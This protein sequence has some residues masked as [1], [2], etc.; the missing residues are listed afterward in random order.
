[1]GSPELI[2]QGEQILEDMGF[3]VSVL[4]PVAQE[5]C[6]YE[7]FN[8]PYDHESPAPTA[9][10]TESACPPP[11]F[12][13]QAYLNLTQ[14]VTNPLN[15]NISWFAQKQMPISYLTPDDFYCV[16]TSYTPLSPVRMSVE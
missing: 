4:L 13:S 11:G 15:S 2:A 3:D 10:P 7:G 5:G 12:S 14:W 1:M 16:A 9:Q 6:L 8:D